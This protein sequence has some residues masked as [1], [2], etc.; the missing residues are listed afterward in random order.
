MKWQQIETAPEGFGIPILVFQPKSKF[1]DGGMG[2]ME[3]YQVGGRH[4]WATA[5]ISGHEY[6]EDLTNPTHWMPLPSAPNG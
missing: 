4:Y 3:K 2:V 5:H 1:S 6:D